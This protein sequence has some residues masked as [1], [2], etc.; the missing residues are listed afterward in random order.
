[1]FFLFNDYKL[2]IFF[3]YKFLLGEVKLE[4]GNFDVLSR[5]N[6]EACLS[7]SAAAVHE[8]RLPPKALV[9]LHAYCPVHFDAFHAVLVD[10]SVHTS[11]LK[12][13]VYTSSLK[14]PRFVFIFI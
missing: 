4:L 3:S 12:T 6:V 9:G 2:V 13:G 11:L 1:M 7:T 5:Y 14:V 8:F 10:T